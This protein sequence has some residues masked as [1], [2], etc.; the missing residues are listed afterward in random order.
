MVELHDFSIS[1][2]LN[3]VWGVPVDFE[4]LEGSHPCLGSCPINHNIPLS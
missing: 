3:G 2:M 4:D 1:A